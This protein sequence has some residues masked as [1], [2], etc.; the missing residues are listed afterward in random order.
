MK[1]LALVFVIM[2]F[3]AGWQTE[4]MTQRTQRETILIN[5]DQGDGTYRWFRVEGFYVDDEAGPETKV[6]A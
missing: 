1:R 6:G 3:I 5:V 4:G 2:A